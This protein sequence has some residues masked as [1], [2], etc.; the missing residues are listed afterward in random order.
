MSPLRNSSG[1]ENGCLSKSGSEVKL[2]AA[3]DSERRENQLARTLQRV[4]VKA[5]EGEFQMFLLSTVQGWSMGDITRTLQV[6]LA[7]VYMAKLRVSKLVK[8]ELAAL[9]AGEK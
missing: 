2:V 8:A 6:S 9:E 3:W 4:R 1:F 5:C 7:Q